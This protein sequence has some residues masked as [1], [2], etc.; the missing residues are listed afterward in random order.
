MDV[1]KLKAEHPEV[2]AQVIAL[3]K[4]E[5]EASF[6]EEKK[7]M[8][9]KITELTAEKTQL[10]ADNKT[11][12]ERVT[13]L[14]KEATIRKEQGIKASA[15][16]VFSEAMQRANIPERLRPKIRKQLN[17]EAFIKDDQLDVSAFSAA[18]E[19]ELKDWVIEGEGTQSI[20]GMS[21]T[22]KEEEEVDSDKLVDRMLNYVGQTDAK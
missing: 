19:T 5:A 6:A 8:T 16:A 7:S 14:E 18:I 12:S 9:A 4:A 22:K 11:V 10:T 3:G 15:E 21:S 1:E 13:A 17:H 20:L 2:Y